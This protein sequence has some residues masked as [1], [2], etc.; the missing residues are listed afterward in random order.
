MP[1]ELIETDIPARLDRLR[2]GRFHT[3]VV[4][5]LGITWVLDGLEVTITGAIA[6]ALKSSPV[7]HLSDAQVGMAASFYLVG[8][9]CGALLFGWLTDKLGRKRLFNVTL[10][11]YLVA[12]AL[13]AFSP[14][15]LLFALFRALTGAGIGGEY[16]AINSA[17]QELVPARYRGRVDLAVNGSFWIGA[18]LGALATLV[19]LDPNLLPAELGWRCAFGLGAALGAIILWL[20]Q[21][22]PES[23]RWL[24]LHGRLAEAEHILDGIERVGAAPL[25][26]P[27]QRLHLRTRKLRLADVVHSL[28]RDYPR[29]TVV[30]L[31]LMATQAFFYNAIFFTYALVLGRYYGIGN[32][33][34][35][36][37][38]LPFAAGNFLGPLILGRWFDSFGRKPMIA[39][40]YAL[41]GLLLAATAWL[42]ADGMLTAQTQTLAW[43]VVFFFASAAASSAYLTAGESFPLELRALAIALFYA[44][45][46]ALGGVAGPWLFGVLIGSGD[47]SAIAWGYLLGAA[48]MLIGAAVVARWGVSAERRSLEDVAPPLSQAGS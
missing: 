28:L 25:I 19:L 43:S 44:F 46:T 14:N 9:V 1:G 10:G 2:W 45:G 31:V 7:L 23:P 47:R 29:R 38:L 11:L 18:A 12:T 40:T 27:L 36:L 42:F 26:E 21:W 13:T 48:L 37:F 8:A 41:S 3:L 15:F 20:R 32:D 30:T 4:L 6:G 17:I 16:A 24:V 39:I 5:A 33:R 34:I 22:V 35:G